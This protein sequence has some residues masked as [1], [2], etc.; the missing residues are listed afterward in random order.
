MRNSRFSVQPLLEVCFWND[1]K[2]NFLFTFFWIL[3]LTWEKESHRSGSVWTTAV[4]RSNNCG[5]CP[6]GC[7]WIFLRTQSVL[8]LQNLASPL[9]NV[10]RFCVY[11]RFLRT[12]RQVLRIMISKYSWM[13]WEVDVVLWHLGCSRNPLLSEQRIGTTKRL[14]GKVKTCIAWKTHLSNAKP[15]KVV[16]HSNLQLTLGGEVNKKSKTGRVLW[17]LPQGTLSRSPTALAWGVRH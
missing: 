14:L 4:C 9:K 13:M 11:A 16:V 10:S 6:L 15:N 1:T 2:S 3:Q 7:G 8:C 17:K 12:K 5:R